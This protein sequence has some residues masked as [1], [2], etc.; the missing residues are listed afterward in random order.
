M[1]CLSIPEMGW[2][3]MDGS[4]AKAKALARLKVRVLSRN[5]FNAMSSWG[6]EKWPAVCRSGNR[7]INVAYRPLQEHHDLICIWQVL[8]AR[9]AAHAAHAAPFAAAFA[10]APF[11]GFGR[12]VGFSG[13]HAHQ[14]LA[15]HRRHL[16]AL[17][18]VKGIIDL[19]PQLAQLL[20]FVGLEGLFGLERRVQFAQL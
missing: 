10:L 12:R 1:Y 13:R 14:L 19:Q 16:L 7:T 15:H 8:A 5:G 20:V 4:A 17:V 6:R 18:V 3:G 2:A 9:S 11:L